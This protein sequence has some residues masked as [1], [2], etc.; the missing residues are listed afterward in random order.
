MESYNSNVAIEAST[1]NRKFLSFYLYIV[2]S[3]IACQDW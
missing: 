1:L 3:N 2:V